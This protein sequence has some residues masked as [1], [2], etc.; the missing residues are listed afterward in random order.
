GNEVVNRL[1]DGHIQTK[2]LVGA[3]SDSC[4]READQVAQ[5]VVRELRSPATAPAPAAGA[6][7]A[8]SA[9]VVGAEGGSVDGDVQA[10]IERARGLGRPLDRSTR[11]RMESA[12]SAD[13]GAVRVH[14]GPEVDGLNHN[15]QS[16]AFT[17]GSDIFV[18][19]ADFAPGTRAG[20]E[21]LAHELTHTVQQGATTVRRTL[22]AEDLAGMKARKKDLADALQSPDPSA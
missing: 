7:V 10:G 12:F 3:A 13:F 11:T 6:A 5:M 1:V 22:S 14:T 19:R 8:W 20:D 16:R 4:E 18:R 17:L 9:A 21:L 2:L 15:L